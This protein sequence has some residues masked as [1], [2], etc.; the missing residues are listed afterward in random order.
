MYLC[1]V[2]LR[3]AICEHTKRQHWLSFIDKSF[4]QRAVT[5][6]HI[7]KATFHYLHVW[8][9]YN[10]TERTLSEGMG[11]MLKVLAILQMC[12]GTWCGQEMFNDCS[13]WVGVTTPKM[14]NSSCIPHISELRQHNL[15]HNST[16]LAK[17]TYADYR[18]TSDYIC[19]F[20]P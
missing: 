10:T 13:H 17:E 16:L 14:K 11:F 6:Q 5:F 1:I 3:T 7:G 19:P 9:V 18:R 12:I 15:E 8:W 2:T 20:A 4:S